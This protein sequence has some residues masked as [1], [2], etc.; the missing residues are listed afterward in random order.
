MLNVADYAD[1]NREELIAHIE[2]LSKMCDDY[3]AVISLIP[4]CPEHGHCLP[5]AKYWIQAQLDGEAK[6]VNVLTTNM[7]A[8]DGLRLLNEFMRS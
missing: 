7:T 8:T 1:L 3:H 4:E 6:S 2:L 5:H